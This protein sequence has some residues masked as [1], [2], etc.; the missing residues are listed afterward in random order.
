MTGFSACSAGSG[1]SAGWRRRPLLERGLLGWLRGK[2]GDAEHQP[3]PLVRWRFQMELGGAARP[4]LAPAPR[5]P[6]T[7]V[8][9]TVGHRAS[10][11]QEVSSPA[12]PPMACGPAF[13]AQVPIA[14]FTSCNLWV[15][16]PASG[17]TESFTPHFLTPFVPVTGGLAWTKMCLTATGSL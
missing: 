7:T 3:P 6:G 13:S 12:S 1:G 16:N 14:G 10:A 2:G 5:R 4:A 15:A 9:A 17:G 11:Y 8:L